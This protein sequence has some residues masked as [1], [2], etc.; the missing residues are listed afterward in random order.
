MTTPTN[1]VQYSKEGDYHIVII[2][3]NIRLTPIIRED[4]ELFSTTTLRS[5]RLANFNICI[6]ASWYDIPYAYYPE[7]ALGNPV[8]PKHI[9]NEGIAL[10]A[11]GT[12]LGKTSP[13]MFYFAQKKDYTFEI[14]IGDPSGKKG[15]RTGIGGLC[16]LVYNG[17]KYGSTN[18][19]RNTSQLVQPEIYGE[20]KPEHR[21]YL[22]RRSNSKYQGLLEQDNN[23]G[24]IGIGFTPK[25]ELIIIAQEDGTGGN[26]TFNEFRD[27]FVKKGCLNACAMDGSD[28]VFFTPQLQIHI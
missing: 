9:T 13:K 4:E 26:T 7:A 16:P 18:Q 1:L 28:S 6:N 2:K 8:H 14:G 5:Q 21:E 17:L 3:G 10:R 11:N 15:H 27:L 23:K 20:P 24:R 12:P 22:I 25:G 19:Y